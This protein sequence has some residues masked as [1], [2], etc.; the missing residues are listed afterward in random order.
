MED[1]RST[2]TTFDAS[3][4]QAQELHRARASDAEE[5]FLEG[6]NLLLRGL[7]A[8]HGYHVG[9]NQEHRAMTALVVQALNSLR[10]AYDLA[11]RG[12][13]VQ[14]LNLARPAMEDWMG[15]WY[16]RNRPEDHTRFTA[17]GQEP[18][19]FNDMLQKIE[20]RQNKLRTAAGQPK[21]PP[22]QWARE[23]IKELHQFSHV[24]RARVMG[25]MR[26]E[27]EF[28]TFQVGSQPDEVWFRA[29]ISKL[30]PIIVAH[31]DVMSNLRRLAGQEPIEQVAYRQ[32]VN[33]W[34]ARQQ[35]VID[36]LLEQASETTAPSQTAPD[37]SG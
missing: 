34:Q 18:P 4:R 25:T 11:L 8:L 33:E 12:Y 37:P 17:K 32:R 20:S 26:L 23:W 1:S 14:A 16:L 31:L 13:F 28:T 35:A 15:Y 6:F 30:L 22:E 27:G 9:E 3:D 21:N 36:A 19:D 24:S 2:G 5:I 10:C 29:A 7:D